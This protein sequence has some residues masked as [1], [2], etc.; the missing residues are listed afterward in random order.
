MVGEGEVVL[1]VVVGVVEVE[2]LIGIM[3]RVW[4]NCLSFFRRMGELV[5]LEIRTV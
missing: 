3:C 2:V 1:Y 4:Y 5:V